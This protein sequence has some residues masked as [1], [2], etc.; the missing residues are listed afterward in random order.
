MQIL[1]VDL[2][3]RQ[4]SVSMVDTE[5]REVIEKTL[6]HEGNTVREFYTA[7]PRPALVGVEA[8]G[9]MF[10][11]LQLLE[12]LGITYRVGHPAAIRKAEVRKQ[13]HDRRNAKLIRRL[14]VEERFPAIWL[15]TGEQRDLRTLLLHRQNLVRMRVMAK[16]GLQAVALSRDCGEARRCGAVPGS[17]RSTRCHWPSTLPHAA[18]SCSKSAGNWTSG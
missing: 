6:A 7:L 18:S 13:K 15:P 8:R 3:A 9:S 5:T 17:K 1:S 10:W 4:Q 16:N 2:H 11:F 14:L 12:E